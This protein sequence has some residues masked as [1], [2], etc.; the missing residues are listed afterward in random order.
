MSAS[1]AQSLAADAN[2]GVAP[3]APGNL[4]NNNLKSDAFTGGKKRRRTRKSAKRRK[5]GKK[6][7]GEG[8]EVPSM[9]EETGGEGEQEAN[10][11][12]NELLKGGRKRR[13]GKSEKRSG[14]R[15]S[16]RR[17]SSRRSKKSSNMFGW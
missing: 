3:A 6:R 10:A 15:R 5:S 16:S 14:K 8:D 2:S 13:H 4:F 17:R 9:D 7:G 12:L 11:D 1:L